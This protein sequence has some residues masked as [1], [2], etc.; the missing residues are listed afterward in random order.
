M[1]CSSLVHL[2]LVAVEP[3]KSSNTYMQLLLLVSFRL[4]VCV[5]IVCKRVYV[6]V[7]PVDLCVTV[8]TFF[9]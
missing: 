4:C 5:C 3:H 7:L 8:P 1:M 2:S 6:C 9:S